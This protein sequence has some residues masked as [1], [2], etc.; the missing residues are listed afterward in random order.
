M[1][2]RSRAPRVSTWSAARV[3]TRRSPGSRPSSTRPRGPRPTRRRRRR[4]SP[5]RRGTSSEP[6]PQPGRSGSSS[7][8]SSASTSSR[9]ATTRRRWRRSRR[10]SKA[11]SRSGS[12]A[13]P[14]ST[15]SSSQLVGW[16][17]QDGVAYLPEMRTQLVAARVVAETLAD[18]AE[19]PEIENGRITEVA[20]P[21]E[22]RLADVAAALFAS[23]GDSIEIRE[24]R[25]SAGRPATRTPR[26][27]RRAPCCPTRARSSP[28][29]ASRSGSRRLDRR[30][31]S[32][33]RSVSR[34]GCT[35]FGSPGILG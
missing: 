8:R 21:R 25:E 31:Q 9:A 29:P 19:E 26:P 33:L 18:A 20:G 5:P 1:W 27:M 3:S 32:R 24:G 11:R 6:A 13:R 34:D 14:S 23:R 17:I 30:S 15:S 4:S 12:F 10:C 22:E 28:A 7:S 35:R 16:M 2:S